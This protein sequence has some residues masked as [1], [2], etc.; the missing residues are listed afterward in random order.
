MLRL[1]GRLML[2]F[3]L[4]FLNEIINKPELWVI[5]YFLKVHVFD[6][7]SLRNTPLMTYRFIHKR[8][9]MWP[10]NI[11]DPHGKKRMDKN[12]HLNR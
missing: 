10:F 6:I 4:L 7:A 5:T 3:L 1:Q 11:K 2:L 9:E 8:T 12:Q